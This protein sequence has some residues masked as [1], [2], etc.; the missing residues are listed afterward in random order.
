VSSP[1]NFLDIDRWGCSRIQDGNPFPSKWQLREQATSSDRK[2]MSDCKARL[3]GGGAPMAIF[4]G[5]DRD[6]GVAA[7]KTL[8]F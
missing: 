4:V 7:R 8:P 6:R 2:S 1:D 3:A 5:I